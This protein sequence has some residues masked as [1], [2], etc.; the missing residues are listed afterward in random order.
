VVVPTDE[1]KA[2]MKNRAPRTEAEARA[3]KNRGDGESD[4][5]AKIAEMPKTDLAG[6]ARIPTTDRRPRMVDDIVQ[7][8]WQVGVI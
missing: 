8:F 3:D 2:A 4:V 7:L 6:G 1:E 5:L